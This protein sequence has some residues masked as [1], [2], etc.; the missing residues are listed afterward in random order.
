MVAETAGEVRIEALRFQV[1][2][3]PGRSRLPERRHECLAVLAI[4]MRE[5]RRRRILCGVTGE[6]G[7]LEGV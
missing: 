2:F 5:P 3:V 7:A 6:D 1:L 4:Q